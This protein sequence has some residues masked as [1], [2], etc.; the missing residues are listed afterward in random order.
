MISL[1]STGLKP[2]EM[3]TNMAKQYG[4]VFSMQIGGR[5][6]VILNTH[7]IIKEAFQNPSISDRPLSPTFRKVGIDGGMYTV[8]L[9]TLV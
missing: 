5:V 1:Y 4:P 7:R 2:H 6:V 8:C 9:L 3:L